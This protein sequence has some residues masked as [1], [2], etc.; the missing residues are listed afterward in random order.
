MPENLP[1]NQEQLR[2][3][4]EL[5]AELDGKYTNLEQ[6]ISFRLANYR[7]YLQHFHGETAVFLNVPK[8][9]RKRTTNW[10]G[11]I[12][13]ML[14]N[15]TM[16]ALPE[17]N[18]PGDDEVKGTQIDDGQVPEIG[19][20]FDKVEAKEKLIRRMFNS[21]NKQGMRELKN[22]LRTG[23][24][25]GDTLLYHPY[26]PG[27]R[28]FRI[29]NIFPGFARVK[30]ANDNY[31]KIE[32]I[33]ITR[34]I[35][36]KAIFDTYGKTVP[37]SSFQNIPPGTIWD[38]WLLRQRGNAVVKIYYDGKREVH[39]TTEGTVLKNQS[40][41]HDD[42]PFTWIP[43]LSDVYSP[44]GVSYLRDIIPIIDEYN[45]AISDE[46]AIVKLFSRPKVIIKNA[47]Q[48][49]L[50]GMKAMWKRGV[51][52]SKGDL[53]V[54]PFEFKSTTFPI[55]KR[56]EAIL[57]R[58]Y[59][60]S[61][62]GPAVFGMPPGS[63]NTGASLTLEYA[64]T[65]QMA[66]IVWE[67]WEPKL[68][69]M[70]EFMLRNWEKK[71]QD[72]VT[73]QSF[74][75]IIDGNYEVEFQAPFRVPREEAVH[76]SNIINKLQ[77]GIISKTTAMKELGIKSPQDELVTQAWEQFHP[78]ITP[79]LE[80]E[81]QPKQTPQQGQQQGGD[82]AAAQA[83]GGVPRPSGPPAGFRGSAPTR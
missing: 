82:I 1:Q 18:C 33:F 21:N 55:E 25:L 75:D 61:G 17:I 65:L 49:D 22:G 9:R 60:I 26:D 63:I 10:S 20:E 27:K 53:E 81:I 47:T 3:N 13:R 2:T 67:S 42:V 46:D 66:Q 28:T 74:K 38:S 56:I 71:G 41:G 4:V 12:V 64:P 30:F 80:Q 34:V 29:E 45:D 83:A 79:E 57:Q 7:Y 59:Q 50:D 37:E 48:K 62:F 6:D 40:H 52:A 43:A 11:R 24:S 70:L 51:V 77:S 44:F 76:A 16:P 14:T 68:L 8:G 36:T 72:P 39:Y 15:F 19:K 58:L 73:K 23:L 69:T 78:L 5:V 54:T 31:Q 35:S 32:H